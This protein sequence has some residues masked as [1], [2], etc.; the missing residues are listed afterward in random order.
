MLLQIQS[1]CAE[2]AFARLQARSFVATYA[3][4]M[5]LQIKKMESQFHAI[6][7][8]LD[9]VKS[10]TTMLDRWTTNGAAIELDEAE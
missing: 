5:K 6:C 3:E 8:G 4:D 7:S 10:A 2:I 1:A 9:G